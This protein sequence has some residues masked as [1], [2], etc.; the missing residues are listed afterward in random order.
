MTLVTVHDIC[1]ICS[2]VCVCVCVYRL[3]RCCVSSRTGRSY[4]SCCMVKSG[5]SN[6]IAS[7]PTS[8]QRHLVATRLHTRASM[9]HAPC[10][11]YHNHRCHWV[12][13]TSTLSE[14]P[15]CQLWVSEKVHVKKQLQQE[16]ER[17]NKAEEMYSKR[18]W[19]QWH[20]ECLYMRLCVKCLEDLCLRALLCYFRVCRTYY[21]TQ[22][23]SDVNH[24]S[25]G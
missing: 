20:I 18:S 23:L 14:T 25:V 12:L 17:V 1:G 3:Q 7:W 13:T 10:C 22:F 5:A 21:L 2:W 8:A 16:C 11:S 19:W 4:R 9:R 15:H 6:T 24:H